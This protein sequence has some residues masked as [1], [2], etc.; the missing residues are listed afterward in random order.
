MKDKK[1]FIGV[2]AFTA[3][4]TLPLVLTLSVISAPQKAPYR[5]GVNLDTTGYGA[6][7][8]EPEL[9]AVQLYAE[10]VNAKGGIDGHPL[11]LVVYDTESNPEKSS[12]IAKKLIQR[13]KVIA[14]IGTSIT[15]TSN[16]VKPIAQEEKIVM[17]CMTASFEPNFPDSFCFS[18][19]VPTVNQTETIYDYFT[20]K[21]IKRVAILCSTDSSGEIWFKETTNTAK[22]YGFEIASEHFSVKDMDVTAQLTKLKAINPQALIVGT[23]GK[24]NA[25]VVKNFNQMGFKIP[26]VTGAGNISESFLKLMEGNEPDTLLL[27]G[28]Y[29]NVWRE[30]P[31]S[32]PQKKLIQEFDEAFQKKF[33]KESD[34]YAAGSYDAIRVVTEAIRQVKPKGPKDSIKLRDSIEKMKDFPAVTG[35]KYTFSKD[36]H[37]GTGKESSLVIQVKGG[38]F[39][40]V[41]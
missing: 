9:K 1:L 3:C 14:I 22:K 21:G 16:A 30:L 13:D 40:M 15:T 35:T 36:N 8:G 26:Y 18:T 28:Y 34:I 10:Q 37:R 38:K 7:L 17:Y 6:W 39:V 41:K 2:I 33:R 24:P 11:E 5:I 29:F 20:K 4:F 12:T 19:Y 23:A 27:S 31:D 32:Y 25:V